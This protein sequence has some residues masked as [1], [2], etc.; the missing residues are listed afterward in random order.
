MVGLFGLCHDLAVGDCCVEV[1]R[2]R[3][4]IFGLLFPSA[5]ECGTVNESLVNRAGIAGL[6][7]GWIAILAQLVNGTAHRPRLVLYTTAVSFSYCGEIAVGLWIAVG[8]LRYCNP[9]LV[10]RLAWSFS[11]CGKGSPYGVQAIPT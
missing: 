5:G 9:V 3:R 7:F 1:W 8:L 11:C 4:V 2:S 6:S 10:T